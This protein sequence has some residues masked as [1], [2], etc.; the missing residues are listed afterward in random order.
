MNSMNMLHVWPQYQFYGNIHAAW[1]MMQGGDRNIFTKTPLYCIPMAQF[2]INTLA[3]CLVTSLSVRLS[4][5]R[6][7][8]DMPCNTVS[9]EWIH[10]HLRPAK[11]LPT[12]SCHVLSLFHSGFCFTHLCLNL[13]ASDQGFQAGHLI[14]RSSWLKEKSNE[15]KIAI[16]CSESHEDRA[17]VKKSQ[18]KVYTLNWKCC[19]LWRNYREFFMLY[20]YGRALSPRMNPGGGGGTWSG[21]NGGSTN[22]SEFHFN[23]TSSICHTSKSLC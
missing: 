19:I 13:L 20:G 9:A 1:F 18:P 7:G 3:L 23:K 12:W 22:G 2:L 6:N 14:L 4:R 17:A 16:V 8:A 11:I 21:R 15:T 10:L 5:S